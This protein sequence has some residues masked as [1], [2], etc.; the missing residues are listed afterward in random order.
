MLPAVQASFDEPT[1]ANSAI[2][3]VVSFAGRG[4][5]CEGRAVRRGRR[6]IV[7]RLQPPA[8]GAADGALAGACR[9]S[10]GL[11]ERLPELP[12]RKWNYVRQLAGRFREGASLDDGYE[13]FFAAVSISTPEL[14]ARIYDRDFFERRAGSATA[15]SSA[16][17]TYFPPDERAAAL[18]SRAVH[19]GRPHRPHARVDVPAARPREHGPFA[20]SARAVPVAPLRRFRADHADRAQAQRQ[21]R[22][23]CAAQGG[24]AVASAGRARPAQDRLPASAR[25]LVHGRLQRFCAR[26]LASSG[27]AELGLLDRRA[28][29]AC[30]T[31]TAAATAD[32]GRMLYA[33]AMFSC[34]WEQQRGMPSRHSRESGN[35]A[36]LQ[37][38]PEGSGTPAFAGVSRI[39]KLRAVNP[40][41]SVV[42]PVHN[43]ADVLGARNPERSRSE[44][45]RLRAD[46]RR[47][48]LDRRQRRASRNRFDD[49]RIKII[50]LG[51]NRGGNAARNAGIRAAKAPLIA[52]LDSDDTYLPEKLETRRR[53]V[54]APAR[55]RPARRQLRQGPAV[56][57]RARHAQ[58]PGDRRPR[59]LPQS[60][61]HAPLWKATPSITV[62]ARRRPPRACS[63][64]PS[65]ACRT[66]TS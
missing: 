1:A 6:R 60:P 45:Q 18:R 55:A 22:Q 44:P 25:R 66:S 47:R 26:S 51:D 64:R 41:V 19:D 12:S 37:P 61:V 46:R 38:P 11:L 20:R 27:A 8:L 36:F 24:R 58:K 32:H 52:F 49:P 53:R 3:L 7:P 35:P 33:I 16:R 13:R 50:E 48:R 40:A 42:L 15:S 28:S 34:W 14:R 62:K 10:A 65:G 21:H 9:R 2:P 5:A 59:D 31:S 56:R 30:S 39:E 23:I 4:R 29:S 57:A 43:R 63:T 17:S 54:R